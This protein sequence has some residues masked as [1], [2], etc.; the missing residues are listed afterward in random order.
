VALGITFSLRMSA[1]R[2]GRIAY[3]L[4]IILQCLALILTQ[5]RAALIGPVIAIIC[6][7]VLIGRYHRERIRS[8]L[9]AFGILVC[10]AALIAWGIQA[11]KHIDVT[12]VTQSLLRGETSQSRILIWKAA[13]QGFLDE[14]LFGVGEGNFIVVFQRHYDPRIYRGQEDSTWFDRSHNEILDRLTLGGIVGCIAYILLLFVLP[15]MLIRR[16]DASHERALSSLSLVPWIM[17]YAT[18]LIFFFHSIADTLL[19]ITSLAY[20]VASGS[21]QNRDESREGKKSRFFSIG[22]LVLSA[23]LIVIY[24]AVPVR[25]NL[26]MREGMRAKTIEDAL[27]FYRSAWDLDIRSRRGIVSDMFDRIAYRP[28][29]PAL[30]VQHILQLQKW[31]EEVVGMYP[32]EL[33]YQRPLIFAYRNRVDDVSYLSHAIDLA[34]VG[35]LLSPMHPE[36]YILRG[37]TELDAAAASDDASLKLQRMA[38]ARKDFAEAHRLSPEAHDTSILFLATTNESDQSLDSLE[39][40]IH[41]NAESMKV[42]DWILTAQIGMYYGNKGFVESVKNELEKLEL[43]DPLRFAP[44]REYVERML[45]DR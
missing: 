21:I 22:A 23:G 24:L 29:D 30:E 27:P 14:P 18:Y 1:R 41:E 2:S 10:S 13:V 25:A 12:H 3:D 32:F 9:R 34:G 36:P 20:L 8:T 19:W 40:Y 42:T 38:D 39:G 45:E 15:F 35:V 6:Y 26:A 33:Q 44:V 43:R 37:V 28:E 11:T 5:A 16:P 17:A 4:S 7:T 31:A